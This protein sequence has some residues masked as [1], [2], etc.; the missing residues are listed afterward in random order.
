MKRSVL[1]LLSAS[2]LLGGGGEAD[3]SRAGGDS[4]D[5]ETHV[6]ASP[7]P[8]VKESDAPAD[9]PAPPVTSTKVEATKTTK[10]APMKK[11]RKRATRPRGD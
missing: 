10:Q 3:H 9:A 8:S 5:Q 2:V 11:P 1:A 7:N 4:Q 6:I